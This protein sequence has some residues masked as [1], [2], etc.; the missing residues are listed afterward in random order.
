MWTSDSTRGMLEGESACRQL[1]VHAK[2]SPQPDTTAELLPE[3]G[4]CSSLLKMY[5]N[6]VKSV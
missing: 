2:L 1:T 4:D 3:G 5:T 6:S